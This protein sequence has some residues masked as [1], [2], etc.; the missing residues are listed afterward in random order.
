ME[1]A[2]QMTMDDLGLLQPF[3]RMSLRPMLLP[4]EQH[5]TTASSSSS[6]L[7]LSSISSHHSQ[8]FIGPLNIK[9]IAFFSRIHSSSSFSTVVPSSRSLTRCASPSHARSSFD[10]RHMGPFHVSSSFNI[11]LYNVASIA[12]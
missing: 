12:P 11:K 1:V 6:L 5:I 2:I 4:I 7:V 10:A 8:C 3:A 9:Q